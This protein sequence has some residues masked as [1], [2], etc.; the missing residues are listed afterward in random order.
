MSSIA[1]KARHDAE[2][3]ARAQMFFGEGAGTRRKIIENKVA[4]N[5]ERQSG[6]NEAFNK[7]LGQQNWEDHVN[8][9]IRERKRIDRGKFIKR[10]TRAIATGNYKNAQNSVLVIGMIVYVAHQTG[11]DKVALEK[12]KVLYKDAK[13]R[14][15]KAWNNRPRNISSLD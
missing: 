11:L 12:G 4:W 8:R 13:V 14:V 15:K 5:I 7:A 6:Y 9:A 1:R 10:N 2:E 3:Y